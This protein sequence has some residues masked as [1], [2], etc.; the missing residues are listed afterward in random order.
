MRRPLVVLALAWILGVLLARMVPIDTFLVFVFLVPLLVVFGYAQAIRPGSR[1]AFW[2]IVILI[3]ILLG[4]VR[5]RDLRDSYNAR[6]NRVESIARMNPVVLR[7]TVVGEP[8]GRGGFWRIA[9]DQTSLSRPAATEEISG[10]IDLW[11][12][13]DAQVP[14]L[15]GDIVFATGNLQPYS[16][17]IAQKKDG[18]NNWYETRGALGSLFLSESTLP[19]RSQNHQ[20]SKLRTLFRWR[21]QWRSSIRDWLTNNLSVENSGLVMA[22]TIGDRTGLTPSLRESLTRSGLLH[23]TAI[24]GLHVTALILILPWPLKLLGLKRRERSWI[25]IGIALVLLFLVGA[26]PPVLRSVIMGICLLLG[27][28]MDRPKDILNFL[29][30]ACL[31]DLIL[32]PMEI[33]APGF[34]FSFLVVAA[35]LLWGPA[36]SQ[37]DRLLNGLFNRWE[38]PPTSLGYRISSRFSRWILTGLWTS[39]IAVL[40]SAPLSLFH[41]NQIAFGAILGNLIAIPLTLGVTSLGM[42]ATFGGWVAPVISDL[43]IDSLSLCSSLLVDWIFWTDSHSFLFYRVSGFHIIQALIPFL[44]LLL[45]RQDQLWLSGRRMTRFRLSLLLL[46]V[47]AL[48]PFVPEQKHF[49][50]TFLDVGQ[51]DSILLEFPEGRKL[52]VDSGPSQ[53]SAPGNISPLGSQLLRF[54]IRRLDGIFITH[55]ESDHYG[56]FIDLIE[57]IPIDTLYCSGDSNTSE[58]FQ[59]FARDIERKGIPIE[60]VLHGDSLSGIRDATVTVLSPFSEDLIYGLDNRNERSLV[61]LVEVE[62]FRMLLPGDIGE[63]REEMLSN[64]TN[65]PDVDLLKIPH[66]GSRFSTTEKFL[67]MTQPEIAVIQCGE[68]SHGHPAPEVLSRLTA[69]NIE[70]FTTLF[71]GNIRVTWDG[72]KMLIETQE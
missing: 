52:L 7:G 70:V 41:F 47:L 28:L 35:L 36:F 32:S 26:R 60:R 58:Q 59:T 9:V 45:V 65:L 44:L 27:F 21:D 71:D 37:I 62:G 10:I 2:F 39:F 23:I 43:L 4:F 49:R 51:G 64:E 61:I 18:L 53:K 46:F 14:L 66:H 20:S 50:A 63:H 11:V 13:A 31:I 34:Q 1:S 16:K 67:W 12:R 22:M 15:S 33:A 55:P 29:G 19:T 8:E 69:F 3:V 68:N 48:L 25:A 5:T 42:I 57:E 30:A 56:G 54:G 40:A 17:E 38:W 24:S 6:L 72:K